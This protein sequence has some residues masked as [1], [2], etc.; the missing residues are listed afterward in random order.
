MAFAKGNPGG[1]GRPKGSGRNQKCKEWAEKVGLDFL[2]R[3]AEGKEKEPF[4]TDE[5]K[6]IKV[7]MSSKVRI[8]A[9]TYLIDHGLGKAP[10]AVEHSGEGGGDIVIKFTPFTEPT[11]APAPKPD[12][13][14]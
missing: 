11:P 4:V 6:V 14:G 12:A 5:G 1:P 8:T 7:P 3:V 2:M 9:A 13:V 10:Q